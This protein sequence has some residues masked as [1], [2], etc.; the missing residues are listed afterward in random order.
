M[1][2]V[3]HGAVLGAF[4]LLLGACAAQQETPN[5]LVEARTEV[6]A[7]ER[8]ELALEAAPEQVAR[9]KKELGKAEQLLEERADA[10]LIKHHAY[11]ARQAARTAFARA[12]NLAA[13]R[14]IETADSRR[15]EILLKDR[16]RQARMAEREAAEAR[17]VAA[18][19]TEQAE[20][21]SEEAR[22]ARAMAAAARQ[23]ALAL[24]NEL[25][26][27]K[28][29]QTERG[30]VLT[31]SDVLF[32][33]DE[34]ELKPGAETTLR[35]LADFLRDQPDQQ[36]RIEGHTDS[37]GSA[38]YNEMLSQRRAD[39]V[40]DALIELGVDATRVSAEG[41]GESY[42][43]ATNDT[44]AGRQENRRVEIVIADS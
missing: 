8:H 42:P 23:S 19:A 9:A 30:M 34:A 31:L 41:K 24:A 1:N 18:V 6:S 26:E 13:E 2:R 43:I 36:I 25:Q 3:I 27:L 7:L 28:A 12:E 22:E 15:K 14:K 21:Q 17:V 11:V 29:E 5:V 33:T 4:A 32:D 10:A 44:Q 37:R 20:R 16:E 40:K 38:E 35:R 39:A